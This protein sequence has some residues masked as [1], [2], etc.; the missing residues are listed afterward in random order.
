MLC[1]MP[2]VVYAST[3][4]RSALLM[5]CSPSVGFRDNRLQHV[6]HLLGSSLMPTFRWAAMCW[7]SA[8]AINCFEREVLREREPLRRIRV[9]GLIESTLAILAFLRRSSSCFSPWQPIT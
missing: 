6:A 8:G 4:R 1:A 9:D 7:G 5:L 2:S 3:S